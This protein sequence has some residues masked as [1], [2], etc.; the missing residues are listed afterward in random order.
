VWAERPLG[1]AE[2]VERLWGALAHGRLPHALLFEGPAG[3]GKYRA[4]QWFVQGVFCER[5]PAPACGECGPCK[6]VRAGSHPDLHVLDPLERELETIPVSRI[7]ERD[8]SEGSIESFLSLR[9]AEGG[10]RVVLIREFERANVP[11]QNALLKTLEEP[12]NAS[13]LILETSR[14]DLLLDT[15]RSRCVSVT[16]QPPEPE[17]GAKV[18]AEHGITGPRAETLVRWSGGSPGGALAL[19]REGA[20]EAREVLRGVLSGALDP[21]EGARRLAETEGE[22]VGKTPAA[23]ARARARGALDLTLAVL[24]DALRGRAGGVPG[25]LAHGDLVGL[26]R[27]GGTAIAASLAELL[28]LRGEVELNISPESILDRAMLALGRAGSGR[29]E[30][31]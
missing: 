26:A 8:G 5:G 4:A 27:P 28:S 25:E 15:V 31:R 1:H 3:I 19:E 20:E 16:L 22:F 24:R 13:L 29:Q 7:S 2:A 23:Q 6:R 11:A 14:R 21:L 9:P 30:I 12:G 17:L 18:L 10:W